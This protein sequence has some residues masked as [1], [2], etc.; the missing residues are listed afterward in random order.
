MLED[1]RTIHRALLIMQVSKNLERIADHAKGMADMVVYMV[2]GINVR[3]QWPGDTTEDVLSN[4]EERKADER[5]FVSQDLR[6]LPGHRGACHRDRPGS[7][8]AARSGPSWS[9]RSASELMAHA[10]IVDLYPMKEIQAHV[11]R[12]RTLPGRV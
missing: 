3:H 8:R 12:S 10:R 5:P 9:S 4:H 7:W 2:T 1:A 6:N 11:A